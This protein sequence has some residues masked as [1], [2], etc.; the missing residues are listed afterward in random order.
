MRNSLKDYNHNLDLTLTYGVSKFK[1][2][3]TTEWSMDKLYASFRDASDLHD[4]LLKKSDGLDADLCSV[5]EDLS[6]KK[7]ACDA[8]DKIIHMYMAQIGHI[9]RVL[10][11]NQLRKSNAISSTRFLAAQMMPSSQSTDN[12]IIG[13]DEVAQTD[14]I[15]NENRVRL[16]ARIAELHRRKEELVADIEYLGLIA[17]QLQEEL[18]L[19]RPE[20]IEMNKKRENYHMWLVQRGENDEKIQVTMKTQ[21]SV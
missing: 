5:R 3:K 19:L 8:F 20:L 6:Q 11:E 16:Q 10:H 17:H 14:K 1:F 12:D 9:E 18:D 2:G 7:L 4:Q 15:M 13:D 21:V